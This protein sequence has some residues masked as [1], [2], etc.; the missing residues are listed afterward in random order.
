M[1][2]QANPVV[3]TIKDIQRN[4]GPEIV[5]CLRTPKRTRL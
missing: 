2:K 4:Q 5:I 1:Y 3:E